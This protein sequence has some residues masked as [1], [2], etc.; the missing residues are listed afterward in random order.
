LELLSDGL[1]VACFVI[2][3]DLKA[4]GLPLRRCSGSACWFPL[5]GAPSGPSPVAPLQSFHR[6]SIDLEVEEAVDSIAFRVLF[7]GSLCK[8][9]GLV[10]NFYLFGPPCNSPSMLMNAVICRMRC[11]RPR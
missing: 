6:A 8:V 7:Q 3:L 2:P 4:V 10:C 1:S 11:T 9:E 5:C